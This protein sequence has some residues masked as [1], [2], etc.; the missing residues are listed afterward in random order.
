M[1]GYVYHHM[2]SWRRLSQEWLT[3]ITIQDPI[4]MSLRWE[5]RRA[6]LSLSSLVI[7]LPE[8]HLASSSPRAPPGK[9][10]NRTFHIA[11]Y[12]VYMSTVLD[13]CKCCNLSPNPR[14]LVSSCSPPDLAPYAYQMNSITNVARV[15][16]LVSYTQTP[17]Y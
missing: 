2:E 17:P 5:E 10:L 15:P 4:E 7:M 12:P 16:N 14:S 6:A 8:A 11:W 13:T 3:S 9:D 1:K